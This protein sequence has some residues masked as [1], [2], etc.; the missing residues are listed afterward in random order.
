MGGEQVFL[1]GIDGASGRY[2]VPPMSVAA[3]AA[4]ARGQTPDAAQAGRLRRAR[5]ILRRPS[6][7][8]P[9]RTD[10]LNVAQAGWGVVFAP[11]AP[12]D[13]RDA[14]EPLVAHRRRRV[15]PDRCKSLELEP[16]ETMRGW[17]GRQGVYPGSIDPRKVPYYLL[18]V[19]GPESIPFEFQCLLDIEYAV[20][21]LAFDRPEAYRCYAESV[22]SYETAA[23]V[24]NAKEVVYW[25][26]RHDTDSAT[27]LS[28][29]SLI[30]PLHGGI[31]ARGGDPGEPAIAGELGYT[32]RLFLARDATRSNLA[33]VLHAPGKAPRPALLVTASHGLGLPADDPGQRRA[34][35]ALLCQDWT[36]FGT[37]KP[38]H[39]LTAA[40]VTDDARLH[41]LVAFHFACYSAGTPEFD[42]FLIDEAKGRPDRALG[43]VRIAGRPFV[44]AL[45]QRLL[46]HPKGGAMAVVGHVERA[47]GYSIRPPGLG[48]QLVPFRNLLGRILAGEPVGHATTDLSQ[49]YATLAADL[50]D[51]IDPALPDAR[52]PT[53]A[54]LAWT[55]VERNDAQNYV[56]LGDPAVRL[57]EA[58]LR[59]SGRR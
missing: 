15:P 55:W 48:P 52:R 46:S 14:L 56:V 27:K 54:Q 35:G 21:R 49:K 24:P 28:A 59:P 12:K 41:G 9:L 26:T 57:R 5:D 4:R 44:A 53:D 50:L 39:Y 10:P 40:D 34:N 33:E 23:A 17:L 16:G 22:V 31:P 7:A 3:A 47:W 51:A 11:G 29:D 20:G 36:G 18:L 13:V 32:S 43:P 8:L 2:L 37:I 25:G 30:K 45:P 58:D 42:H 1:N 38:A 19:G 6:L